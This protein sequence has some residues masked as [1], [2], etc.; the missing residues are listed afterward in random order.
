ML[1]L[2]SKILR[3][4]KSNKNWWNEIWFRSNKTSLNSILNRS[5]CWVTKF[6]CL[7]ID[8]KLIANIESKTFQEI[9]IYNS[10][11]AIVMQQVLKTGMTTIE[12]NNLENGI[13]FIQTENGT[14][15]KFVKQ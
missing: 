2:T 12:V 11:G 3:L 6:P 15:Q 9:V 5:I 8:K 14:T 10:L 13:Y 7:P 1:I 4:V